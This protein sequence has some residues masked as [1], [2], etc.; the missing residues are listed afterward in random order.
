MNTS[1]SLVRHDPHV[2]DVREDGCQ[3]KIGR[4]FQRWES[5]PA[6]EFFV[7]VNGH[8]PVPLFHIFSAQFPG[9]FT[10]DY[11]RRDD[12]EVQIKI[13]RLAAT[14]PLARVPRP[15][16]AGG[17]EAKEADAGEID[18]RG[19][20]PPEPMMIILSAVET[21]R[22]GGLLKA[23]T[24]RRPIHLFPE[25]EAR[26]VRHESTEQADGSWITLLQRD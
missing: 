20:M 9:A 12:E 17:E 8:D 11:L 7:L 19:L 6:G 23:R 24:D 25:L 5:L 10:W 15:P 3:S 4:I 26:G 22:P 13:T 1:T 14:A 16:C 2:L 18:V 21:L